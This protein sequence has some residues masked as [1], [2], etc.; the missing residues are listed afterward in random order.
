MMLMAYFVCVFLAGVV[1]LVAMLMIAPAPVM[2]AVLAIAFVFGLVVV[3]IS[4]MRTPD[5]G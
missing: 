5:N 4:V 3:G 2:L 1:A